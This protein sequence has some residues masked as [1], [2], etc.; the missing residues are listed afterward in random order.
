VA[1]VYTKRFFMRAG[2]N[3]TGNAQVP[4]GFAWVMVNV[5][6]YYNG[7]LAASVKVQPG[8]TATC[9]SNVFAG[10]GAGPQYASWRGRAYLNQGEF[11]TV[12][13]GDAMD[14]CI[15]GYQLALP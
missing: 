4:V 5:D 11:L 6:A 10:G 2:L 12:Q 13:T 15:T 1:N 3:G 8:G 7:A 9:W 14:I